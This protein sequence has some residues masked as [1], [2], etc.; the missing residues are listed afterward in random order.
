MGFEWA[1]EEKTDSSG[2]YIKVKSS[3]LPSNALEES[4]MSVEVFET[5]PVGWAVNLVMLF[6]IVVILVLVLW[7]NYDNIRSLA[8]STVTKGV[9][10]R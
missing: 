5:K 8:L 2:V 9:Q 4:K 6:V 10:V 3:D 7:K 1:A